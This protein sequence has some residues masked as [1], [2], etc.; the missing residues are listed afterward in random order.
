MDAAKESGNFVLAQMNITQ[1]GNGKAAL[2]ANESVDCHKDIFG[3]G[4]FRLDNAGIFLDGLSVLPADT[5]LDGTAVS[6]M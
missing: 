1:P 6:Q 3:T 4:S 5:Q 2:S